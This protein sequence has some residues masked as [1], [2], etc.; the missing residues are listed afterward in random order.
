MNIQLQNEVISIQ[1]TASYEKSVRPLKCQSEKRC[2]IKGGC[3]EMA[4]MI[5]QW[6]NF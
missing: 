3:Q 5:V 1:K 4:V 6:P 2:E